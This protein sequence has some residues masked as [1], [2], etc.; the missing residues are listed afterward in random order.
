MTNTATIHQYGDALFMIAL[1]VPINGFDGF[2]GSWVHTADPVVLVDVGPAAAGPSLLEA[3]SDLGV[4][5]LDMILLTHI[6]IDH[7]GGIGAIA[8][9]FSDAPVVCHPKGLQHLADPERLWQGSLKTLGKLAEAYGPIEPV[10]NDQLLAAD[11]LAIDGLSSVET[12]GHAAHHYSYLIGDTLFAG[13]AC[14]V[15][16]QLD[17]GVYLRPATPPKFYLETSLSSLDKLIAL[18]P[19]HI[20]YGHV[21][22]RPHAMALMA[23]HRDQ[24]IRW[25]E[26]VQPF[27]ASAGSDPSPA[28]QKCI[29]SLIV[30][31]PLLGG[32]AGLN[33]AVQE[34]ELGF[35]RNSVL[36]YW[37]YLESVQ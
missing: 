18:N 31:D 21:G 8:K 11:Q 28:I 16:L 20:C 32:F 26:M 4:D 5:R 33:E 7:A 22:W 29:D 36:G 25:K 19:Q 13:E 30:S 27:Y 6:H 35:L 14:G 3:L 2:I 34:R 9:R 37:G 24:L 15:N 17:D 1:P 10:E 12:P 23:A